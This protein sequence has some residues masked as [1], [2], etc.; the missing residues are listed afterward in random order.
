MSYGYT[1]WEL[2]ITYMGHGLGGRV[3]L[4][5]KLG[6]EL[7][8]RCRI[9]V[10]V[11]GLGLEFTRVRVVCIHHLRCTYVPHSEI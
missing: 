6:L 11:Y 5:L 3:G 1:S 9:R 8:C 4:G 7:G 2:W 10:R